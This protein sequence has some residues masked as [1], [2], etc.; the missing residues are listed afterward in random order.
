MGLLD[1][2]SSLIG[3]GK[4]FI[5]NPFGDRKVDA[6]PPA[7]DFPAGFTIQEILTNGKEEEKD[8]AMRAVLLGNMMPKVPFKY[9]GTQRMMKEHYPGSDEPVIHVMGAEEDDVVINGRLYDKRYRDKSLRGVAEKVV[10]LIELMRRRGNLVRLQLG[11]WQRYGF[12]SKA[13]F[14]L[15][16]RA[17]IDYEITFTVS[18]EK[19]PFNYQIITKN[20]DVPQALNKSLIDAALAFQSTYST[21]PTGVPQ[22]ISDILNAGISDVATV[23]STV[24]TFVDAVIQEGNDIG[25]SINRAIGLVRFAQRKL[26]DYKRTVA[27][28]SYVND[29]NNV[30]L[31]AKYRAA[32]YMTGSVSSTLTLQGILQQMKDRFSA[33]AGTIPISRH[34]VKDGDNLQRISVQ[35]YGTSDNWKAIYDHNKLTTTALTT[36]TVLE[37]PR[38]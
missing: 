4:G 24:T 1:G 10:D 37:I 7:P 33:I 35:Q 28:I 3:A 13:N 30:S 8:G 34:R 20:Q 36:G 2:P 15:K 38:V 5:Q 26:S 11:P 31:S 14:S 22:S 9:G 27:G 17:D 25:Q 18:G 16:T 21:V 23:I 6:H 32:G 29:L 12:I 19:K